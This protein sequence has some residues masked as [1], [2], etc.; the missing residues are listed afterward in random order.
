MNY[1]FATKTK[2]PKDASVGD[3]LIARG[4]RRITG[5]PDVDGVIVEVREKGRL[6]MVQEDAYNDPTPV[7]NSLRAGWISLI[8]F[9]IACAVLLP[10]NGFSPEPYA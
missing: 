3:H 10:V 1:E 5:K 8:I 7:N 9:G 6:V 2:D 4:P